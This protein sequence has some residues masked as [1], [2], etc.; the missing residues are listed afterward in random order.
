VL[1]RIL[2]FPQHSYPIPTIREGEGWGILAWH[3]R[4]TPHE[5]IIV[6]KLGKFKVKR[7]GGKIESRRAAGN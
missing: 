7:K 3:H 6:R 1:G 5:Q 2:R 4:Q